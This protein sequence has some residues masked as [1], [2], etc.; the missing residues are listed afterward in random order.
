MSPVVQSYLIAYGAVAL[1]VTL[2]LVV[3]LAILHH[4]DTRRGSARLHRSA[5][6]GF[7]F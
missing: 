5:K 7:F 6:G 4:P 2:I 1:M 3:Y